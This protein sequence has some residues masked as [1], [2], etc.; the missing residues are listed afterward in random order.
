MTAVESVDVTG[1]VEKQLA[2]TIRR[3]EELV[4][5]HGLLKQ[6]LDNT[7]AAVLSVGGEAAALRKLLEQASAAARNNPAPAEPVNES[8]APSAPPTR[9]RLQVLAEDDNLLGT[10]SPRGPAPVA[11][12]DVPT[13]LLEVIDDLLERVE[14]LESRVALHTRAL[15][16]LA[17]QEK[18]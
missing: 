1:L 13:A 12:P 11:Q 8:P 4:K 17:T 7:Y 3:Y 9:E 14:K 10:N 15:V 2:E 18:P 6:E 16:D 5:R